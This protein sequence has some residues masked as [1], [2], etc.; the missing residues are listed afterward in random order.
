MALSYAET[1]N[2]TKTIPVELG[3][4][5]ALQVEFKTCFYTDEIPRRLAAADGDPMT[6]QIAIMA[7]AI[8]GWDFEDEGK[9]VPV[10]A[11][12]LRP[13]GNGILNKIFLSMLRESVPN[14]ERA[15]S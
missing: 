6:V 4:D 5:S 8:V 9:P 12:T 14:D 11:D 1:I 3:G 2:R 7:E 13:L 10:S 15:S